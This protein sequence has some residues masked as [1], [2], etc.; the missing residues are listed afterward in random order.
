MTPLLALDDVACARGGRLLVRR[1]SLSLSAGEVVRLDGP[2]GA[3]KSSLLRLAAGLLRP[4]AGRV[5]RAG[6]CA[7]VD[8]RPGFAADR[9][10][11]REVAWWVAG[12]P[13]GPAL[14]AMGIA[15]LAAVPIRHLS[16]GQTRRAALA[17]AMA[18]GEALW[19]LDEPSG[20]LDADGRDR[21]DKAV[22]THRAGGGAVLLADHRPPEWA[23]L[24]TV[25]L[26]DYAPDLA[27]A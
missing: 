8:D 4:F 25:A 16:L 15:H 20:S 26:P 9:P 1:L 2:N 3:G 24:R 5:E 23:G 13:V 17:R 7:L 12:R 19:L 10:L 6:G 22:A 21:L 18:G 14:T 11:E 27:S